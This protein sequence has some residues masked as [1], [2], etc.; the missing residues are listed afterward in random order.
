MTAADVQPG[1]LDAELVGLS[2]AQE[3]ET[4]TALLKSALSGSVERR[5]PALLTTRLYSLTCR[6][7]IPGR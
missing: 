7:I 5:D 4:A 2:E 1:Y 3:K 6:L